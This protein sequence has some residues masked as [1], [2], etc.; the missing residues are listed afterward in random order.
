MLLIT[1]PEYTGQWA[2]EDVVDALNETL[3]LAKQRA[4]EPTHI[5]N[6]QFAPYLPATLMA[7]T[8]HLITISSNL[9]MNINADQH[10][11]RIED[12]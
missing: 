3:D 9:A 1:A 8:K 12:A 4:A 10:M 11:A 6:S 7:V 5:E 2:W